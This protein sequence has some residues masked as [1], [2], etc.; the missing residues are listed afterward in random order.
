MKK[1]LSAI[2]VSSFIVCCIAKDKAKEHPLMKSDTVVWAGLDYSMV[3][4]IGTNDFR[5]M[6]NAIFPDMPETWNRLFLEER[7][8][9]VQKILKRRVIVD[10]AG[11]KERNKTTTRKQIVQA[12]PQEG[13]IASSHITV[14]QIADVL[15]SY[16]LETTN[17]LGLVFIV[18]KFVEKVEKYGA[19]DRRD[20]RQRFNSPA[21]GAVYVVFFDLSSRE[22]VS[23][24]RQVQTVKTAG[25]F[26]NFW[27][28]VIKRTDGEL[29]KYRL[30]NEDAVGSRTEDWRHNR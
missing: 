1:I 28:G 12:G 5:L 7:I 24:E 9:E 13:D 29:E 4:M 6:E 8:S 30:R 23:I 25:N 11:V 3:R 14:E 2:F 27:F 20:P 10:I 22:V 18:E 16:K 17:G 19:E 15:K 26:R 21:S